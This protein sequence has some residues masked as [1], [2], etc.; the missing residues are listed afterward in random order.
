MLIFTVLANFVYFSYISD[1]N[2]IILYKFTW[3][4]PFASERSIAPPQNPLLV[5]GS[6]NADKDQQFVPISFVSI[7]TPCSVWP[8]WC[9]DHCFSL[10]IVLDQA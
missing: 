6:L 5:Y 4:L 3:K 1:R 2:L 7:H 8:E 10:R 9:K